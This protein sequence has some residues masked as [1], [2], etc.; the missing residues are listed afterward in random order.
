MK[1]Y[2]QLRHVEKGVV[3]VSLSGHEFFMSGNKSLP[4]D[5]THQ[6]GECVMVPEGGWGASA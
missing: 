4:Q 5:D 2:L 1:R 6:V 3:S